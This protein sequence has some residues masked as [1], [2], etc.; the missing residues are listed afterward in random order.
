MGRGMVGHGEG[1]DLPTSNGES[2]K[3]S[4]FPLHHGGL[5]AEQG[6]VVL[7]C[8]PSPQAE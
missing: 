3:V 8:P 5:A 6:V 4:H 2:T 7:S 1:W